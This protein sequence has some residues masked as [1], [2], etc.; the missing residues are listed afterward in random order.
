[1]RYEI[2]EDTLAENPRAGCD[3]L[4]TILYT[5][6]RYLLGDRRVHVDEIRQVERGDGNIVLPV[7]AYVHSG[8][9]L[10]T[11]PFTCP[12]DSGQCGII[13]ATEEEALKR[14]AK[15]EMTP[16]LGKLVEEALKAEVEAFSRYLAGEVLVWIV[17]DDDGNVIDSCGGYYDREHAEADAKASLGNYLHERGRKSEIE[18][19]CLG[20][21]VGAQ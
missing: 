6:H 17:L 18:V 7:Y 14:F 4:G 19:T 3:H 13:Y 12:W 5:S 16:E 21:E 20:E 8:V 10:S 2:Q 11:S 1:M 9:W 15:D